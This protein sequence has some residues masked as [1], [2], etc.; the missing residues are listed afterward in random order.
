MPADKANVMKHQ[1]GFT[2]AEL[3][4][5]VVV[6]TLL[7]AIAAPN[8]SE[9]VKNNARTTRV[10]TMVSALN[11]ARGLAVT[12]NARVSLCKSSGPAFAACAAVGA[13][14]FENGWIVF[15]DGGVRGTVDGADAVVRVFQ[16][17][18]GGA[19]TLVGTKAVGPAHVRLEYAHHRT[20]A[21]PRPSSAPRPSAPPSPSVA[22]HTRARDS[23]GIW[24]R[25]QAP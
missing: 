10:N 13:G 1:H 18:M 23:A 8:M 4:I 25:Q 16:P 3:M 21:A 2:I 9:F 6:A 7:A 17:D 12:R 22:S 15:T 24:I 19:A 14:N 20:W 5:V 11:Y